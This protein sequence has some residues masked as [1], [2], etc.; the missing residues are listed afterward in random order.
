MDDARINFGYFIHNFVGSNVITRNDMFKSVPCRCLLEEDFC[1]IYR[2]NVYFVYMYVQHQ[3]PYLLLFSGKNY[4]ILFSC[5]YKFILCNYNQAATIIIKQERMCECPRK[6]MW[7]LEPRVT[8]CEMRTRPS[9]TVLR[10]PFT[11]T[12]R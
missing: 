4:L 5:R 9:W 8:T 10:E 11:N 3:V 7:I 1:F 12:H 6:G 2:L